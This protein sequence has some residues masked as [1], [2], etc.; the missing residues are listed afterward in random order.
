MVDITV[1][2]GHRR[3][4]L[5]RLINSKSHFVRVVIEKSTIDKTVVFFLP[6]FTPF[7]SDVVQ[8]KKEKQGAEIVTG[9]KVNR[10]VTDWL[11][12][13]S[14]KRSLTRTGCECAGKLL[15]NL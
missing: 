11:V 6:L 10:K 5:S 7:T 3:Y 8:K 14:T 9:C 4:S 1:N 2:V 12:T 13:M 15:I